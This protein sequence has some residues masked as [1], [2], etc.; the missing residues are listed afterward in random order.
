M[1]VAMVIYSLSAGGAER[2]LCFLANTWVARGIDL[3]IITI[4]PHIEC[5]FDLDPRI[6][7]LSLQEAESPLERGGSLHAVLRRCRRLRR[8]LRDIRPD[9]VVAFMD[10]VNALTVMEI[11][12]AHV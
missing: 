2:T 7:R 4:A 3:T 9:S 12:R 5:F 1:N 11:G 6:R 10:T 8:A